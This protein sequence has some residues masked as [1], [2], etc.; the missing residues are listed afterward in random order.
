MNRK[1][2]IHEKYYRVGIDIGGTFTDIVLLSD[3]GKI[4]TKKVSSTPEEYSYGAVK[5]LETLIKENNLS[6]KNAKEVV[7]A[8]TVATNTVLEGKGAKT[9][10]ITTKGFRDILEFRRVR[11]PE[12]YNLQ[13]NKPLPLVQRRNRFE[14]NERID[15]KGLINKSL[16]TN[17]L[18]SLARKINKLNIEAVAICFLHSYLNPVHENKVKKILSEMLSPEI[19][20]CTSN[21]I[22]PEIREYE[23]TSTTVVNAYL[24]PVIRNYLGKFSK[25]LCDIGISAPSYVMQSSG[26]Q[27][28][29]KSAMKCPA[30]LLESGP[31][32]GVIAAG[33]LA[34]QKD[35]KEIITLDIGGTTAKTAL[36]EN[37]EPKRTSE[38]EVGSGI[39]LSSKLTRGAGYAVK[40][41][42]IDI[43]EIGAGG[44]SIVWFDDGNLLKVGPKSAG[45]SPGPIAYNKGGK[46][47][48]LTDANIVLGFLN[49][50]FLL[51]GSMKIDGKLSELAI[52]KISK[53]IS[54]N[55]YETA[56]GILKIAI[57][58]MVRAVKS[59][60]TYQG[61]DP[62]NFT[63]VV[64]GGNGSLL[65]TAIADDLK[66]TE[67]LI[68]NNSGV[69]SALGLLYANPTYE[70]V[71]SFQVLL[72]NL[73]TSKLINVFDKLIL[74]AK[75]E[76]PKDKKNIN[77][78]KENLFLD[79]RYLGQAYEI[80]VKV[81]INHLSN[82]EKIKNLFHLE[83]EKLYSNSSPS[84]LVELVNVRVS[85]SLIRKNMFNIEEKS[86]Y[87][88]PA[89]ERYIYFPKPHGRKKGKVFNG[90]DELGNRKLFGP[91]IIEEYDTTI[92]IPNNWYALID[93]YKN[94]IL[95]K[96][97]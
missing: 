12:L 76:F 47:T 69:L 94:I 6:F 59:V 49:S 85:V 51:G 87:L 22:L 79:L 19:F 18:S 70:K 39:N 15:A 16:N 46:E 10:L 84:E 33:E 91:S 5:G 92:I 23:R 54:L 17:E 14:V 55:I 60:T 38:Y 48:T 26:G 61:K 97:Q 11:F 73:S 96:A 64:Y 29:F 27:M 25:R 21:E 41:P 42:F 50:N 37:F 35:I 86:K 9:A 43:S 13:Y 44:G 66:I 71:R 90:R 28:L 32:A 4:F 56:N 78:F 74:S 45:S 36:I 52:N 40:L 3:D 24:G 58:N 8:T 93:D 31:A 30:Y 68:P 1:S 20:L 81:N 95:R 63:M 67:I 89:S 65:A 88:E 53:K 62:R 77:K 34:K 83:H 2:K 80:S 7:H 72:D 57:G 75:S 82:I